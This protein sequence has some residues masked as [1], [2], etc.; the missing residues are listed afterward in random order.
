MNQVRRERNAGV[1]SCRALEAISGRQDFKVA[2]KIPAPCVH[3]LYNP[4]PLSV[5]GVCEY[6]VM[7][8]L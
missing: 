4:L 1:Q 2:P 6:N 3:I 5:G 7:F 8:L